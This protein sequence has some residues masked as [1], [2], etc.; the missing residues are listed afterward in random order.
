[1][2][3]GAKWKILVN[4]FLSSRMGLKKAL[5]DAFRDTSRFNIKVCNDQL[6]S[7]TANKVEIVSKL[8]EIPMKKSNMAGQLSKDVASYYLRNPAK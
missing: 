3:S 6:R 8:K 4:E 5:E 1:M 7:I 2:E